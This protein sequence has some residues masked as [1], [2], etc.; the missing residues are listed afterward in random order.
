MKNITAKIL[1]SLAAGMLALCAFSACASS[2]NTIEKANPSAQKQLLN[3]RRIV[4][5]SGTNN[6]AAPIEIRT[7]TTADGKNIKIQLEVMNRSR[8]IGRVSYLVEWFDE[9]GMKIEIPSTWRP[10]TIPP[11]KIESITAVAPTANAK[12]FRI[13]LQRLD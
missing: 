1:I 3:D 5:D 11:A 9:S 12:D 7:G 2:V 6:I 13:S 10:L 4:T 8:D